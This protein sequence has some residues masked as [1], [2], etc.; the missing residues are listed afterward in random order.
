MGADAVGISLGGVQGRRLQPLGHDGV[1][2]RTLL[3]VEAS[4]MK[5]VGDQ[6]CV[7]IPEVT[8]LD[9]GRMTNVKQCVWANGGLWNKGEQ[10]HRVP[11]EAT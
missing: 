5:R 8:M 3:V 7:K 6:R 4:P 9:E 10:G 11:E 1:A 2:E